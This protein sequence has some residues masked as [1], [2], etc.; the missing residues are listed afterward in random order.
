MEDFHP[1]MATV[2]KHV[3]YY[4]CKEAGAVGSMTG[5]LAGLF[6]PILF[7]YL[8]NGT[9]LWSSCWIL[10]FFLSAICLLWKHCVVEK[11]IKQEAPNLSR[12]FE[13]AENNYS[14]NSKPLIKESPEMKEELELV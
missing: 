7:G 14:V 13:E 9:G 2:Y 12:E 11:T 5:V 3:P 1:G 6:C 4:I 10:M 8:L